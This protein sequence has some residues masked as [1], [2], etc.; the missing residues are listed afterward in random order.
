MSK[1]A[2][3]HTLTTLPEELLALVLQNCTSFA[4][5]HSAILTSRTLYTV[6]R[7]NQRTILWQVGQSSVP[8][9]SEALIAVR[10]TDIAKSSVLRGELPPHP[11]PINDLSGEDS[12]PTL[13]EVQQVQSFACLAAYLE[14]RT[15]CGHDKKKNFL[16]HRWYFD[17]LSWSKE[18]WS[19]WRESYHRALYRY[20]TA[21]AVLCRAYY[22]PLLSE[23]KPTGF[24]Y[25]LLSMLEGKVPRSANSEYYPVW[26][27]EEEK[28]YLRSVP[29]YSSQGY[30]GGWE[31]AFRPLEELFVQES[32]K[33]A[34]PRPSK[35]HPSPSESK[36]QRRLHAT[37]GTHSQNPLS[38]DADHHETLF[39]HLLHFLS[40]ID[41]DIRYLISL[42]GDTPAEDSADPI[43]HSL[44]GVFLFGSFTLMDITIRQ[45]GADKSG[46][47]SATDYTSCVAFAS[48]TLP[49]LTSESILSTPN[50]IP[51][52]ISNPNTSMYLGYPNMHNTL[53]KI[54]DVSGLPNCYAWNPVHKT[55]PPVS[56]FVEYMLR[57]YYG[58]RFS[59]RMFDATTEV[60]CAWCAFHQFGGVFTGFAPGEREGDGV[61]VGDD[62]F[63]PDSKDGKGEWPVAVFDEYA[64]YY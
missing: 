58:L 2:T 50:Q 10:A 34:F 49:K 3:M 23:K 47:G 40:L 21:G 46:S 62:L 52:P 6:W 9:F 57:K 60:R 45:K 4:Q 55:P 26:F 24:L 41:N 20:L 13:A 5:L 39:T 1:G 17:S 63:M 51:T 8:G 33:N 61:Y 27:T 18:T 31:E 37:F 7:N 44:D 59:W 19:T 22:E 53:K 12:K 36:S 48:P 32:R 14:S 35:E 43:I 25:S 64:W 30:D 38:L 29:L 54:W 28:G 42:P 56:L 15:R 16:P 11:F